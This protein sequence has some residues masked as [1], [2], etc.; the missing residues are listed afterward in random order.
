M[1]V[2]PDKLRMISADEAMK[3]GLLTDPDSA[4][5]FVDAGD[6]PVGQAIKTC[7]VAPPTAPLV[8]HGNGQPAAAPELSG[9]WMFDVMTPPAKQ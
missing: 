6:C 3:I 4:Y 9:K 1:S 5:D 7:E 8:A 2:P